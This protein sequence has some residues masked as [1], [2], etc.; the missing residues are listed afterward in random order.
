[1]WEFQLELKVRILDKKNPY[2]GLFVLRGSEV[3]R[4]I[5]CPYI[6]S[7]TTVLNRITLVNLNKN[8]M[9]L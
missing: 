2:D 1:M 8:A 9:N 7:F 3:F 6:N 4:T 5:S